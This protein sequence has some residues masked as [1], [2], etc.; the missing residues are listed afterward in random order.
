MEVNSTP[1]GNE[2]NNRYCY[3]LSPEWRYVL[4]RMSSLCKQTCY[5]WA[6]GQPHWYMGCCDRHKQC[7]LS[8]SASFR[9]NYQLAIDWF[10]A[11]QKVCYQAKHK[12]KTT[13]SWVILKWWWCKYKTCET[14]C[15]ICRQDSSNHGGE[16]AYRQRRPCAFCTHTLM[17]LNRSAV[18]R[19]E[20]FLQRQN[21][22]KI[23]KET[24]E[25]LQHTATQSENHRTTKTFPKSPNQRLQMKI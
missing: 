25:Y 12:H 6:L 17:P 23:L 24:A 16:F 18:T 10:P 2:W 14:W 13:D 7:I 9:H 22:K 4:W 5:S 15:L 21:S 8:A 19:E 1:K 20:L 11:W 3:F